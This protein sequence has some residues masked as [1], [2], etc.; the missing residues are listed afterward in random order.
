MPRE[1]KTT[2]DPSAVFALARH[3]QEVE[4]AFARSVYNVFNQG[5]AL[6]KLQAVASSLLQMMMDGPGAAVDAALR[7]EGGLRLWEKVPKSRPGLAMWQGPVHARKLDATDCADVIRLAGAWV[8]VGGF[9][10][11]NPAQPP[12]GNT[13]GTVKDAFRAGGQSVWGGGA[14]VRAGGWDIEP[15][16]RG[17]MRD[18]NAAFSGM[19]GVRGHHGKK[20]SKRAA[21]SSSVLQLDRLYG[22]VVA[23]DISGTTADCVFALELFGGDFGMTAAY[24]ML[25]L[26]TIVH[27]M[28]H[29]I[30]EVALVASLNGEM[31]YH[32][33][34]FDSLRPL[35]A[36][37]FPAELAGLQN[38]INTADSQMR[39]RGLHHLRY[40]ENQAPKGAF[41]F[42]GAELVA[43]RNS[44]ISNAVTMLG[45][46]PCL[47]G[48][49]QRHTVVEL[50][51][52]GGFIV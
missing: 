9:G 30:L 16:L 22:L 45:R 51:R 4:A 31:D 11:A 50:L 52:S 25:P 8:E 7:D 18:P 6:Q 43:L 32:V 24:Y 13:P 29:S 26:G 28:H 20:A 21:G 10:D 23:C 42:Q 37:G 38:A 39:Q 48:F 33:G 47:G 46:A 1:I 2:E 35:R 3:R 14:R 41:Q 49:P 19:A 15:H 12:Q 5:V 34:F 36:S 40:Y 17:H 44:P 27:N